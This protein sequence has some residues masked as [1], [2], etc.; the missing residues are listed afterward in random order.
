MSDE[1]NYQ[2][3]EEDYHEIINLIE[4]EKPAYLVEI[5]LSRGNIDPNF[6]S[7]YWHSLKHDWNHSL[8][9]FELLIRYGANVNEGHH[10]HGPGLSYLATAVYYE[11]IDKVKILLDYDADVYFSTIHGNY[12]NVLIFSKN[13]EISKLIFDRMQLYNKGINMTIVNPEFH[14]AESESN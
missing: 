9:V 4:K 6:E 5:L 7:G 1:E 11:E 3:D 13:E 14:I 10:C 8:E 2:S 12:G